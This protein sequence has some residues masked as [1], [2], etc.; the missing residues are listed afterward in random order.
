MILGRVGEKLDLP[1]ELE[2]A[3]RPFGTLG[4][5]NLVKSC[6]SAGRGDLQIDGY[7]REDSI[8]VPVMT[9]LEADIMLRILEPLIQASKFDSYPAWSSTGRGRATHELL[10]GFRLVE[11]LEGPTEG[12]SQAGLAQRFQQKRT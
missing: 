1:N 4:S 2:S 3:V 9:A 5:S 8:K 11:E 10:H 6:L 7:E 12:D